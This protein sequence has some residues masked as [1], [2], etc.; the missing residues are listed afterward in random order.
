MQHWSGRDARQHG[1]WLGAATVLHLLRTEALPRV[2]A[3]IARI[4]DPRPSATQIRLLGGT[5]A[6]TLIVGM[7]ATAFVAGSERVPSTPPLASDSLGHLRVPLPETGTTDAS[8]GAPAPSGPSGGASV[9][10]ATLGAP[11]IPEPSPPAVALPAGKGMWFHMIE[12][13]QATPEE[14]AAHARA[15]GL[16]HVYVRTGSSHMGFYAQDD[17]DRI[18]PAAHA[19]GL[20]VVGWDFPY[21][22]DPLED[23]GRALEAISYTTPDGHRIDAFSADIETPSEGVNLGRKRV[24]QYVQALRYAAGPGYPRHPTRASTI[25]SRTERWPRPSTPWPRWSTGSHAIRPPIWPATSTAWRPS[26]SR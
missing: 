23:A 16:T 12:Q 21:L 11:E 17:L 19:A 7:V 8:A 10:G 3:A 22:D 1:P 25:R 26:G 9:A 6:V 15:V 4:P 5:V 14:I 18:L 2:A 24:E 13:A 20:E